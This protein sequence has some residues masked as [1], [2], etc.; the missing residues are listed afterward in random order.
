[1]DSPVEIDVLITSRNC[2]PWIQRCIDSVTSQE[3]Q[4]RT[5]FLVDDATPDREY[6]DRLID[7][8]VPLANF[9]L[10][11]NNTRQGKGKNLWDGI[12]IINTPPEGVIFILD[13]DDFLPP[14]ALKRIAEIYADPEVWL[15]YGNYEPYPH[16]TG[17]TKASAYPPEILNARSF[18]AERMVKFNHPLTFR[19]HLWD[20]LEPADLQ[21]DHGKWFLVGSDFV[22]MMPLLEMAAP[23]HLRFL[24][25]TLYR[26]NAVNPLSDVFTEL[27]AVEESRVILNRPK[28]AAL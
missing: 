23:T 10:L 8:T 21:D 20:H 14:G 12:Q 22:I 5:V 26:Y 3:H 28:K 4:P 6:L 9:A 16:N 11:L 19:R 7:I 13:G 17:Q 15:T 24:D 25:E 1:M 27:P 2:Q 18:R